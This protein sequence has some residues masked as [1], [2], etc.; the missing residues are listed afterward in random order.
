MRAFVAI[1]LPSEERIRLHAALAPLRAL[2]LPVKW[3]QPESLHLTLKFLGNIDERQADAVKRILEDVAKASDAFEMELGGIG[4][5][6]RLDHPRVWWVGI[7]E[8]PVLSLVQQDLERALE[9]EGFAR[10]DRPFSPHVTIGHSRKGAERAARRAHDVARSVAFRGRV[11]VNSIDLMES[12][13][14]HQGSR[15][16]RLLAATLRPSQA[17]ESRKVEPR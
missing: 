7:G 15:Y 12:H 9:R 4:A 11:R 2:D 3:T 17:S 6:P 13:L 8:Q 1:N 10:E 14:S 5:F 16:E